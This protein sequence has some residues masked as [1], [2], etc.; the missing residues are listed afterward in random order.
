LI[1]YGRVGKD[2]RVTIPATIRRKLKLRRGDVLI[3]EELN[4]VVMIRKSARVTDAFTRALEPTLSEWSSAE[5]EEAF[6][7]ICSCAVLMPA[8]GGAP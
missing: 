6:R 3:F 2:G 1:C 5:D 8:A 7:A 4:G